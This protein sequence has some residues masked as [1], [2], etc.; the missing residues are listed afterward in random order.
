MKD[1]LIEKQ[2]ELLRYLLKYTGTSKRIENFKSE[3]FQL[4]S[5]VEKKQN[6]LKKFN[7]SEWVEPLWK[8]DQDVKEILNNMK[9]AEEILEE[10]GFNIELFKMDNEYS[11]KNLLKAMHQFRDQGRDWEKIEKEFTEWFTDIH[12]TF[13]NFSHEIIDWFKQHSK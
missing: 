11:A 9:T 2:D 12:Y 7:E 3:I 10:N 6:G 1:K 5:D 13:R 4:K 8:R